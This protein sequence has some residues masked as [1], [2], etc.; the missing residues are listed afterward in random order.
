MKE[1]VVLVDENNNEIGT[2][3]K[4]EAHEKWILHRAI[5]IFVFNEKWE[6]LLQQRAKHKYHA[7][8]LWTNTVCSHPRKWESYEDAVQRRLQEEMGFSCPLEKLWI[9][10][11]D[12]WFLEWNLREYEYDTIFIWT[13]NGEVNLNTEEAMDYK[14]INLEELKNDIQ[15]NKNNYT[16]WFLEIF[17]KFYS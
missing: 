12:V 17:K 8:G 3:E 15:K 6:F 16:P 1:F 4:L 7:G 9:I 13:Y 10:I 14:W 2:M 5:S 11:Y